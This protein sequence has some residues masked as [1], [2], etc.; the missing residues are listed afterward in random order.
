MQVEIEKTQ[1]LSLIQTESAL[2]ARYVSD[3][4]PDQEAQELK[5]NFLMHR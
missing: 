5:C 4:V 1:C 2:L 3:R